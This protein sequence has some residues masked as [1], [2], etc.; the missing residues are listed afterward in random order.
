MRQ[1]RM[2]AGPGIARSQDFIL[3]AG[4]RFRLS[5]D[6]TNDCRM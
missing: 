4:G 5:R 1:V 2:T 6:F 3:R